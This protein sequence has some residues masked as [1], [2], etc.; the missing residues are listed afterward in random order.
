MANSKLSELSEA[1]PAATDILYGVSDPS[2]T[3]SSAKFTL[4]KLQGP[5]SITEASTNTSV[6]PARNAKYI[7]TGN[8]NRTFTI[9]S[10]GS[11]DDLTCMYF[12]NKSAI[13][14]MS[15]VL[16]D[17]DTYSYGQLVFN[18][19]DITPGS[20]VCLQ[21]YHSNTEWQIVEYSGKIYPTG[22]YV[23]WTG[24]EM[25]NNSPQMDESWV[26]LFT[27]SG[28]NL[29]SIAV[30][31]RVFPFMQVVGSSNGYTYLNDL[32]GDLLDD[33]TDDFC[34][35]MWVSNAGTVTACNL[36]NY[37]VDADNYWRMGLN[38]S[39]NLVFE[40]YDSTTEKLSLTGTTAL[41]STWA[42]IAVCKVGA[43]VGLYVNG[44]QEAH[45]THSSTGTLSGGDLYFGTS[46]NIAEGSVAALLGYCTDLYFAAQNIHGAAPNATPD[47]TITVATNSFMDLVRK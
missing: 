21:Y 4:G 12:E 11:A 27:K 13:A 34:M 18:S 45:A 28:A 22:T 35:G 10:V 24:R 47:D 29:Y 9:G 15:I 19:L 33:T 42:H 6:T 14:N 32:G 23:Y 43:D 16:S 39:Q 1:T 41:G 26:Q 30:G 46:R 38:T 17:S 7:Q 3:P 2:G 20:S 40:F 44:T 8:T 37:Y 31:T 5:L 36:F 25:S